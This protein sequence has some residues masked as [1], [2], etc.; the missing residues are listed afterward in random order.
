MNK[1]NENTHSPA[2]IRGGQK[3]APERS[4][5]ILFDF[6]TLFLPSGENR[7]NDAE[8]SARQQANHRKY[9]GKAE[10]IAAYAHEYVYYIAAL[11]VAP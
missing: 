2:K 6:R 5:A 3:S 1:F 9:V 10:N 7:R 8:H 4:R 11:R